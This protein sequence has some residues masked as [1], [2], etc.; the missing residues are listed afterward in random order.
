MS[1]FTQLNLQGNSNSKPAPKPTPGT[2]NK[3]TPSNNKN[4]HGGAKAAAIVGSFMA[5]TLIATFTIGTNGCSKSKSA[6]VSTPTSAITQP[7]A[8]AMTPTPSPAPVA[9]P[10]KKSPRQHKLATFRNS[11]YG[12]TFRYPV[13]YAVKEGEETDPKQT[14]VESAAMNFAQPGGMTL[15]TIELPE[16]LYAGTDF[17]SAFFTVNVN[18]KMTA[19]DCSQFAFPEKSELDNN[20]SGPS[21]V[22]VSGTEYTEIDDLVSDGS[23]QANAH[24]YHLYQNNVCYEFALGLQT[25]ADEAN[26]DLKPVN[27]DKVF[28]KLTW[29]LSTVKIKTMDTTPQVSATTSTPSSTTASSTAPAPEVTATPNNQ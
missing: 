5:A 9:K 27:R 12:L 18:P 13:H 2:G 26:K 25:A 16:S 11:D 22:N 28:D 7:A 21:K 15:S 20:S 29:M 24:Y 19:D 4:Q 3:P 6:A 23:L 10:A 17:A 14:N 1:N 8:P